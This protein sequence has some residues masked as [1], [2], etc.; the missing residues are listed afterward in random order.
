MHLLDYTHLLLDRVFKKLY[1]EHSQ[2]IIIIIVM[3]PSAKLSHN[4][5]KTGKERRLNSSALPVPLCT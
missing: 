3:E 1:I 2:E 5:I 4:G